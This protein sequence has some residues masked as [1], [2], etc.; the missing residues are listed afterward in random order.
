MTHLRRELERLKEYQE[1]AEVGEIARRYFA[2]NSFDGI[3]TI[4][5]VLMGNY[6]AGVRDSA[7]VVVT[8]MTT[9]VS[10][11]VSGLWG[12]YLTESAERRKSLDDLEEQTLTDLSQTRIGRASRVA[13]VI[14]ALVDGLAPLLASLCVLFP[15]LLTGL[16]GDIHYS[17]YLALAIALL[18]LFGLGAFLGHIEGQNML[19]AG[20]KMIVAGVV[21]LV[22]SYL[23]EGVIHR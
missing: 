4:L 23:L 22:L 10:M 12:A 2:M 3:L 5:G 7:V 16:L 21:A 11:G 20:L 9:S 17:Y 13:V 14:V 8:G 6:L 18:S 19:L 1:V 15:F